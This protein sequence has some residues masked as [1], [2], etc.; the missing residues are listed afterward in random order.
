MT[1]DR[2]TEQELDRALADVGGRLAYP[3]PTRLADVVRARLREPRSGRWWDALR[4]PRPTGRDRLPT[5]SAA[6]LLCYTFHQER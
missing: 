4:S 2:M 1:R 6:T 5:C 3:S